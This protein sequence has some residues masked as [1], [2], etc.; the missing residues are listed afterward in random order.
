MGIMGTYRL[1]FSFDTEALQTISMVFFL[2]V[3]RYAG[4]IILFAKMFRRTKLLFVKSNLVSAWP[5]LG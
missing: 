4:D 5:T 3:M 1:H 2:T